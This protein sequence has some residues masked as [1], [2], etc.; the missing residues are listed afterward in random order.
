MIPPGARLRVARP[1]DNLDA[2]TRFFVEGLGFERLGGFAGHGNFDGVM[3]GH[4]DAPWHLEFI[5]ARGHVVGRAPNEAV[6]CDSPPSCRRIWSLNP[7]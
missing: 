7:F 3:L 1:T 5:H 2:L 4:R 6:P